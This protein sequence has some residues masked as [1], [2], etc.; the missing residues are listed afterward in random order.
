MTTTTLR[1]R[2]WAPAGLVA[3]SLV[4]VIAGALRL[5]EIGGGPRL[6]GE[7]Y[8]SAAPGPLVAH[9]VTVTV[10]AL[11]GAFQFAPRLRRSGWHRVAGRL[12]VLSGLGG[13]L[14]GLWLALFQH[15][16]EISDLLTGF[17]LVFGTAWLVFLVLGFAAIRRRD[18]ARHRAWMVR[19]YAVGMG[20]GTQVFTN[21]P[22]ALAVGTPGPLTEAVL[23]LAGWLI[24]LAVAE[25][26][27]RR[28]S[29][30]VRPARSVSTVDSKAD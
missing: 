16:P 11:L 17:R 29:P 5:V 2:A 12:V 10:F 15:R 13:A 7:P 3:L 23:M 4:P 18:F 6:P 21:A 20:A 26:L 19:G 1:H 25:W 24:N 22:W 27:I 28:P 8:Y 9:I 30:G 14:S